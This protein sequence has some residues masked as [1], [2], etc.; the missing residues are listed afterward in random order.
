MLMVTIPWAPSKQ[1]RISW[2]AAEILYKPYGVVLYGLLWH[3][4]FKVIWDLRVLFDS[5][6]HRTY[7]CG[8]W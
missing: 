4:T 1:L 6:G 8:C 3:R 5:C 2:M 7:W